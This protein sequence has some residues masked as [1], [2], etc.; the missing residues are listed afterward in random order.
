MAFDFNKISKYVSA[1]RIQKY[2][3]ISTS[4]R[5]TLKLYQA[6]LRLSQAFYPLLSLLEVVLRNAIDMEM[7]TYFNDNNW[8]RN[9]RNG[10]MSHPSLT[11]QHWRTRRIITNTFLKDEVNKSVKSIHKKQQA[12]TNDK[13]IADL[14][15]GF[16]LAIFDFTH[17]SILNGA[18]L[19]IFYQLPAGANRQTIDDTLTRIRDFRNRVYHNEPIIFAKDANLKTIYDL[20]NA[21]KVYGDIKQLFMWLNLD[22]AMWSKRIDNIDFELK[23][24][25]CVF[26][27]YPSK[28]YYYFRIKL[29]LLHYKKK[30][31]LKYVH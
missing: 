20:T 29:G 24:A 4:E 28:K 23:R 22:Y 26:S 7:K 15:F 9:Q 16:W 3:D 12:I 2:R 11:Y 25:D 14:K 10:F 5:H 8:L 27:N 1:S 30:Y 6:N 18:P 31:S 21:Q 13:I 19:R 17:F